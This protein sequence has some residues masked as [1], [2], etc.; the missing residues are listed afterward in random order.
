MS[1]N[2]I[3]P[4]KPFLNTTFARFRQSNSI[5]FTTKSI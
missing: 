3:V 4:V 1:P 2:I 5:S